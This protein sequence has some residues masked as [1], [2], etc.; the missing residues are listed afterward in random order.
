[1][2]GTLL[3]RC[4]ASVKIVVRGTL[5]VRVGALVIWLPPT[6]VHN[7]L[8]FWRGNGGISR[9]AVRN[10]IRQ[11]PKATALQLDASFLLTIFSIGLCGVL[12]VT[13]YGIIFLSSLFS[14]RSAPDDGEGMAVRG[15]LLSILSM[16]SVAA[17]TTALALSIGSTT[18]ND[19]TN[20]NRTSTT[21]IISTSTIT[22][23]NCNFIY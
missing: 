1:M 18:H 9:A 23:R 14:F 8:L 21:N 2:R 16:L 3:D 6:G 13:G 10:G 11:L 15:G 22:T 5:G 17:V 4:V 20:S 12:G 7:G 19:I